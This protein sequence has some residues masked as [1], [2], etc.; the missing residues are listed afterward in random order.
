MMSRQ[1]QFLAGCSIGLSFIRD[2]QMHQNRFA[3][4][5]V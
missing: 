4:D 1:S 2:T 5:R 3:D